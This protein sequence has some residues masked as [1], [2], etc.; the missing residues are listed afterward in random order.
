[1]DKQSNELY[2]KDFVDASA[3]QQIA[4]LRAMDDAATAVPRAAAPRRPI[5]REQR[6]RQL[7]GDFWPV[8]KGITLHGYYTSEIGFSQELKLQIMPGAYHGC[9]PADPRVG[10]A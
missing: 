4:L 3:A 10:N 8:F 1:M 2:G 7:R 5:N 6:D 9:A